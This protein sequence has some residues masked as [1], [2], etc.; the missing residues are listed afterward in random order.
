VRFSELRRERPLIKVASFVVERR[1][2]PLG[3]RD[4]YEHLILDAEGASSGPRARTPRAPGHAAARLA[5]AAVLQGV[6]QRI[7]ARLA[8]ERG[9]ECVDAPVHRSELAE[10][11]E[12]FLTSSTR[13]LVP[14]TAVEEQRIGAGVPGPWSARLRAAYLEYARVHARRAT[15]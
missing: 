14:V 9:L 2:Y 7:V 1:P 11:D 10:L 6:T 15:D 13:G 12:A 5:G 4:A 3:R 8:S